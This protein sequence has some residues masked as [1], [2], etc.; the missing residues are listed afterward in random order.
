MGGYCFYRVPKWGVDEANAPDTLAALESLR[1]LGIAPPDA[2]ATVRWLQDLQ[3]ADGSYPT[4]VI[5]WAALHGLDVLGARPR[6]PVDPWLDRWAAAVG[7][8]SRPAAVA[9]AARRRSA[10]GGAASARRDRRGWRRGR[11][12]H[13]AARTGARPERCVGAADCRPGDHRHRGEPGGC[14]RAGGSESAGRPEPPARLRGWGARVSDPPRR[15]RHVRRGVVGRFVAGP[16]V[17]HAGPVPLGSRRGARG[18]AARRRGL[19]ARD[20]AISTLQATWL[21][22]RAARLFDEHREGEP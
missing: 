5:G 20:R 15:R 9:G 1:L 17:R 7:N 2:D 22:L 21:G 10:A 6:H 16:N 18:V 4:R 11:R 8:R 14:G 3:Q 12:H 19:G 13:P